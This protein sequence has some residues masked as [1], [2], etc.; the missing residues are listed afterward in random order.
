MKFKIHRGTQEIGGSCVEVWTEKSRILVDLGMPLVNP[1]GSEFDYNRFKDKSREEIVNDGI[2][3]DIPSLYGIKEKQNLDA[4][5]ISH[6]HADHHGFLPYADKHIPVYLGTAT[7]EILIFN[8]EFFTGNI[9]ER[10][11]K[12]FIGEKKFKIGDFTITPY[13]VDHSAFDAYA[14]LIEAEG[15]KLFYT[16]DFRSHGLKEK[17]FYRMKHIAPKDVDYMLMEGACIG[18]GHQR[19]KKETDLIQDFETIFNN[20]QGINMITVS[21]QNIDRI[22]AI[23]QACINCN[24]KLV[25]D[26]YTAAT[27]LAMRKHGKIPNPKDDRHIQVYYPYKL[28]KLIRWK[29]GVDALYPYVIYKI[30]REE[31]STQHRDIV[32]LVRPSVQSDIALIDELGQGNYIYSMWSG[33][34]KKDPAK[35]FKLYLESRGLTFHQIHTS[36]HADEQALKDMVRFI[37]PKTLVPIHTFEGDKYAELFDEVNV[38]RVVVFLGVMLNL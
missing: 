21:A 29:R 9:P 8:E 10:P 1:D 15:K 37:N 19:F 24:K 36:G 13:L 31:I 34:L 2:L 33:Y 17:Y 26:F 23:N 38:K 16:G 18:R 6:Y 22:K 12:N 4:I 32:M 30:T 25:V 3:P 7:Q 5:L 28:A 20:S 14:F 11:F 27:M 35:K